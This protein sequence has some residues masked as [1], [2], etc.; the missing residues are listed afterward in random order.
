MFPD[1]PFSGE[2]LMLSFLLIGELSVLG[3]FVRNLHVDILVL[4]SLKA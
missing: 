2:G 1:D 4:Q 3:R